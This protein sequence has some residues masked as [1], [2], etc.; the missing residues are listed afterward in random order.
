MPRRSLLHVGPLVWH[1]MNRAIQ[2]VTIFEGCHDYDAFL[3]I[4]G[5]AAPAHRIELF[6]FCV[7]PN[8]FHLVVRAPAGVALSRF[9]QSMTGEHAQQWRI[10]TDTSGRGAVYQ[11]RFRPIPVEADRHFVRVCRYV[12]RNPVRAGL[13]ERAEGWRW[14]SAWDLAHERDACRP[15]LAAWPLPRPSDWL[16][17]VNSPQPPSVEAAIRR[18]LRRGTPYGSMEWQADALGTAAT[19]R[20]MRGRPRRAGMEV[21]VSPK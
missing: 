14:S 2:G 5:A 9:M 7:M 21:S 6:A 4:L 20:R 13:V 17:V 19:G 11:G 16:E 3:A 18:T 15:P 12:E 10:E 1:V 8:H